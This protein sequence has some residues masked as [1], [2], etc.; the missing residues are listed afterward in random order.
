MC[1]C[2]MCLY[3]YLTFVYLCSMFCTW[4]LVH[5]MW[6]PVQLFIIF[7]FHFWY[8]TPTA[9]SYNIIDARQD[10][11]KLNTCSGIF[12]ISFLFL[13]LSLSLSLSQVLS[14][15]VKHVFFEWT[16]HS[17]D[18]LNRNEMGTISSHIHTS[19]VRSWELNW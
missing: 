13:T 7:V 4:Y 8:C 6:M 2:L 1:S 14:S 3:V 18:V 5:S 9:N 15:I 10:G 19:L 16:G 12:S 17:T 11:S